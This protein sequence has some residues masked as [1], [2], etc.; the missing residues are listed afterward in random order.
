MAE[1]DSSPLP[2]FQSL[3]EL[4]EYFDAHDLG[5][6]SDR[7]PEAQF[8][9]DFKRRHRLVSIEEDLM[10]TLSE[11]AQ[12]RQVSV[13]VLIEAWLKEKVAGTSR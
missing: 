11:I 1:N 13:E 6:H 8:E 7:M 2:H 5:E 10:S 12:S 3:E 9:A 4:V